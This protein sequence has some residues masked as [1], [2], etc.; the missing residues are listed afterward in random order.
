MKTIATK[1]LSHKEYQKA[2]IKIINTLCCLVH[3]GL[4]G[5]KV[6]INPFRTSL[7]LFDPY[8]IIFI[9]NSHLYYSISMVS[10]APAKS[11]SLP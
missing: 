4:C 11:E 5:K 6:K 2:I 1:A 10:S 7:L 3:L 8:R 9:I